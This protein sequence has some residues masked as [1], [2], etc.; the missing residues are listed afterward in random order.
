MNKL[1]IAVFRAIAFGADEFQVITPPP[2]PGRTYLND[3][4]MLAQRRDRKPHTA[5]R[6]GPIRNGKIQPIRK[7]WDVLRNRYAT[8]EV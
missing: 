8:N 7:W 4:I 1:G 5:A 6:H 3:S 2:V